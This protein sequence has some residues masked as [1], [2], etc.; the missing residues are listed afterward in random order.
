[1]Q[2]LVSV[3]AESLKYTSEKVLIYIIVLGYDIKKITRGLIMGQQGRHLHFQK[4]I[5]IH[6]N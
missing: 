5:G 6:E 4:S 2:S 1:M 3:I